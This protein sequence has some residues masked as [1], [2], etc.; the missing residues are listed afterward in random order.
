MLRFILLTVFLSFTPLFL[1]AQETWPQEHPAGPAG[2]RTLTLHEAVLGRDVR[3]RVDV[4]KELEAAGQDGIRFR[5]KGALETFSR[6]G[7]LYYCPVGRKDEAILVARSEAPGIVMGETVSRNE[8][9]I[10]GGVFWSPDSARIAFFRKDERAVTEFPLLDITTRTG[11]L[12]TIRYPMNGMTSEQVSLGIYDRASGRTVWADVTDFGPDRYL[13]GVSWGPDGRNLFIQVLDR[14]QK[15][16]RLNMY[17]AADGRFVRTVLTEDDERYVEPLD[18]LQFIGPRYEFLYRTANRDGFRQLYLCDTLGTVRRL[19]ACQADVALSAVCGNSVFYTSAEVSPVENHLFRID[20]RF[21]RKGTARIGKAQRLTPERGWHKVRVSTDGQWFL[22]SWSSLNVPLETALR[23]TS[24]K[25]EERFHRSAADPLKDYATGT[26]EMGTVRSADGQ[27]DNYYRLFKPAGF[28]PSKK[29]PLIVYVYGGPHSQ[30]VTDSWLAGVRL[31]ELYMAQRGYVV[32]VQ[33]GRG[34]QNRGLAYE[35][36]IHR[37][38]GQVEMADQM[39]GVRRL[40]EEPWIDG[41][42]IGVHG[43]S[44]GGFMTISL[45]TTYPDVFKVGVAGGPVIDWKWYEIMYGERYME[46]EETNPDGFARTSL[47]G[48]AGDLRG[49]LLIC[50]GAIDNTVVWQHS[51]N[52]IQ[53]CIDAG[54]PVDYFPYPVAEHNVFGENRVHLMDK[55]TRYFDDYL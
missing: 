42:R 10:D 20:L 17:R 36:A 5:R 27:Y 53:T 51:L 47:I 25:G 26:V 34:T 15:H 8:F 21:P 14:S 23:S 9:G 40:M 22:D 30:M 44:Y 45:M 41:G 29:Y 32:Y 50:Q 18:P 13:T 39:A 46:T 48:K 33:D 54:V 24:G 52:F 31:W 28:D 35:Q 49:R 43:W 37:Q 55:V 12:R 4:R 3:P 16:C 2:G 38:C 7:N 19:T 11:T 6:D 1:P